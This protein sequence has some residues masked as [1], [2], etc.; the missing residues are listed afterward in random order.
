MAENTRWHHIGSLRDCPLNTQP[1]TATGI[2]NS[3]WLLLKISLA[4]AVRVNLT[5][6]DRNHHVRDVSLG[7]DHRLILIHVQPGKSTCIHIFALDI[8]Y[9]N[10]SAKSPGCATLSRST[11]TKLRTTPAHDEH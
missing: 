4:E 2:L 10:G 6:E 11:P 8:F 1:K 3:P 9:R 5:I 7:E